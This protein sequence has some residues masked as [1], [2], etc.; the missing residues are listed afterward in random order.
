M[1]LFLVNAKA[2]TYIIA[3]PRTIMWNIEGVFPPLIH[4]GVT[5][6][7]VA[8][9]V[10]STVVWV[11]FRC[12]A[13]RKFLRLY[14]FGKHL[15]HVRFYELACIPRS[16]IICIG[17]VQFRFMPIHFVLDSVG[18]VIYELIRDHVVDVL[19]QHLAGAERGVV[20][21]EVSFLA[22]GGKLRKSLLCHSKKSFRL[23][24]Q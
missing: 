3:S 8:V 5:G 2:D 19:D 17:P 23:F 16:S 4:H 21:C 18:N 7:I 12:N 15:V 9:A 10:W 1:Q 14:E 20:Y 22:G 24:V 6:G 13:V 11:E